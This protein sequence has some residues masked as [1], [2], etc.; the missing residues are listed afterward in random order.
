MLAILNFLPQNF[1]QWNGD[2]D[3]I[4]MRCEWIYRGRESRAG[5]EFTRKIV[6]PKSRA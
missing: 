4:E 5:D 1:E 3:E 6:T 2:L